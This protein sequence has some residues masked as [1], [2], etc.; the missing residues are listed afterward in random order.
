MFDVVSFSKDALDLVAKVFKLDRAKRKTEPIWKE[1]EMYVVE[2]VNKQV[3][4][5]NGTIR[6]VFDLHKTDKEE[7]EQLLDFNDKKY[8]DDQEHSVYFLGV[9]DLDKVHTTSGKFVWGGDDNE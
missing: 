7:V 2:A 8:S 4:D 6:L 1:D 9:K 5:T 3:D